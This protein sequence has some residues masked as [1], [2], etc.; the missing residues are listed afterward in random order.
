MTTRT[1]TAL[2]ALALAFQSAVSAVDTSKHP[3]SINGALGTSASGAATYDIKLDLPASSYCPVPQIGI[4]YNSQSGNGILGIGFTLTGLS[5]INRVPSTIYHDGKIGSVTNTTSDLYALDGNR[6]ILKSGTYGRDKALYT[7]EVENFARITQ[8]GT[9]GNNGANWFEVVGKDGTVYKYGCKT[10]KIEFDTII[11]SKRKQSVIQ[12][13]ISEIE[14][15]N[16]GEISYEYLQEGLAVYVSQIRYDKNTID[17]IY[18][19]RPDPIPVYYD[20]VK[21]K[22]SKR[23]KEIVIK[24]NGSLYRKYEIK[25]KVR[26]RVDQLTNK[27][28]RFSR[29]EKI[30]ES[31]GDG[32]SLNP[33]V[34]DWGESSSSNMTESYINMSMADMNKKSLIAA[35]INGDG[36]SD[37]ITISDD[38]KNIYAYTTKKNANGTLSLILSDGKS[39]P[40][41]IEFYAPSDMNGDG[42]QGLMI[43]KILKGDYYSTFQELINSDINISPVSRSTPLK[44]TCAITDLNNDGKDDLIEI[45]TYT[46]GRF[47]CRLFSEGSYKCTWDLSIKNTPEQVIA[48]DFDGD[49]LKDLLI[50]DKFKYYIF[51]N[52]GGQFSEMFLSTPVYEGNRAEYKHIYT[53]DFNG[54]GLADLLIHYS[55]NGKWHMLIN[56]GRMIFKTQSLAVLDELSIV[57]YDFTDR[58]ENKDF[59]RVLD[60]NNDGKDDLLISRATYKEETDFWSSIIGDSWGVADKHYMYW[61][62]STG[63]GFWPESI[64]EIDK[65][66]QLSKQFCFGDFDGDGSVDI[67]NWGLNC[68]NGNDKAIGFHLYRN[69]TY[70]T[71]SDKIVSVTNGLGRR[72]EIEYAPLSDNSVY[73]PSASTDA[74]LME[75]RHLSV[76][77][78][79]TSNA[80]NSYR[81]KETFKYAGSRIHREGKGF[82]CFEKMEKFNEN[83]GLTEVKVSEVNTKYYVPSVIEQNI[84]DRNQ[85]ALASTTNNIVFHQ[86]SGKAILVKTTEAE[87]VDNVTGVTTRKTGVV[88]GNGNTTSEKTLYGNDVTEN[89]SYTY[90][91]AKAG[92]SSRW[93][94]PNKVKSKKVTTTYSGATAHTVETKYEYDDQGRVTKTT[95]ITGASNSKDN[96]VTE[97]GD[98]NSKGQFCR[99]T[100]KRGNTPAETETYVYDSRGRMTGKTFSDGLKESYAYDNEGHVTSFTDVYGN[101]TSYEYDG[102]GNRTLTRHPDGTEERTATTWSSDN[103]ATIKT[104][105]SRSGESDEVRYYDIAGNETHAETSN[106]SGNV[107]VD[108]EYDAQGRVSRKSKPYFKGGSPLWTT[109]KYDITGRLTEANDNGLVT[110][111]AY[112][113]L[114]TTVTNPAGQT[115]TKRT[116]TVGD[117][118]SVMDASGSMLTFKHNS[119]G[120]V[121]STNAAGTA[122]TMTYD[123]EDRQ[124]SLRD[125][126][127]GE[128]KYE[129]R[130]DGL[131]TKQTDANGNTTET[132]YD[133]NRRVVRKSFFNKSRNAYDDQITYTYDAYGRLTEANGRNSREAY[134]Y[135]RLGRMT[136]KETTADGKTY[137]FDYEY[138]ELGNLSKKTYPFGYSLSYG[139]TNGELTDITDNKGRHIWHLDSK[140]AYGQTTGYTWGNGVKSTNGYNTR[141]ML[142]SQTTG[143]KQNLTYAYDERTGNMTSRSDVVRHQRETFEYDELNRLTGFTLWNNGKFNGTR[144]IEYAANGNIRSK[145]GAGEY[146]YSNRR[147]HAVAEVDGEN[148]IPSATQTIEYN[149]FGKADRLTDDDGKVSLDIHYGID[150]ERVMCEWTDS[151]GSVYKKRLYFGEYEITETNGTKE[152]VCYIKSP[153]G[154]TAVM[155]H[156]GSTYKIYY[157]CTDHLGS[158]TLLMNDAGNTV[159]RHAYD[160][161]G[162]KRNVNDWSDYN[163]ENGKLDRGYTGHESLREFGLINMNGRMYD[164]ILGRML[165]PDNYVQDPFDLQNYNRYT[166]CLNN[167]LKYTDPSG[168]FLHLIVGALIG[169]FMNWAANGFQFSW[170][171]LGHFAIGAAAGALS[172]GIG[173]GVNVAMAGGSFTAGFM[174]AAAGVSSTGFIAGAA[175]GAAAGSTGGFITGFG[176]GLVG[177]DNF[178]ESLGNGALQGLIGGAAGGAI[179]GLT[180][181]IDALTKKTNFWTGKATFDLSKGYGACGPA[182]GEQTITGKYV[183]KFEGVNIYESGILGVGSNSAGVTLPER[184]II[185]GK[186]VMAQLK[187]DNGCKALLQ[188]EFGHILQA[189]KVGIGA[190]YKVIAPESFVSTI[191]DEIGLSSHKLYWTETWANYLSSQYFGSEYVI[192]SRFP[193]QDI[194]TFNYIKLMSSYLFPY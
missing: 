132:E 142:M 178:W 58:N 140:N 82:M 168:E 182:I 6:L 144:T 134:T 77:K 136:R 183:G 147:P 18:E 193:I 81:N 91:Y 26:S 184:G 85:S 56:Q 74:K 20:G 1:L 47:D 92:T 66:K 65:D 10:A 165:S 64:V 148:D 43:L 177:G 31:N 114:E 128:T 125:A 9:R 180:G 12:W 171:G 181:G 127:G 161:W 110:T 115:T 14:Y 59:C 52:Q 103:G 151:T 25:Y 192:S 68:R 118:T 112:N 32:E 141:G 159:E 123:D 108:T 153:D 150:G 152:D 113:G 176:N 8:Q 3:G 172:A 160:A 188:H 35:D 36:L 121:L 11:S 53:G 122:T 190:Y 163:V 23:L 149:A 139:Y 98:Y 51:K 105:V 17:F 135:D 116:N 84:V 194:S 162:R 55:N 2:L 167:P 54:D 75:T 174:G 45:E 131:M 79:I 70:N 40:E 146:S 93:G 191:S 72:D 130:A 124:T 34:F 185:V 179:G 100:V 42:K 158:I 24:C 154:V 76:V 170:E 99:K 106:I 117:V 22:I 69:K 88:D 109:Y 30:T 96:V 143:T 16:G 86:L 107:C 83:S 63:N 29:I 129:Y 62:Y 71:Q 33:T 7:T 21:D 104:T 49:G 94:V 97:Y 67:L 57:D 60:Y 48:R 28:N 87:E 19:E 44:Q 13:P 39:V 164:P 73:T 61:F 95:S 102:W 189:R 38:R 133:E 41:G 157:L 119:A 89:V 4:S 46:R 120:N 169:G 50:I 111:Y 37:L 101:T 145:D 126:D 5:S 166:Y 156:H 187:T 138:D 137:A 80:D 78:S 27:S 155:M 175:T 186:G 90:G 173:A 15:S